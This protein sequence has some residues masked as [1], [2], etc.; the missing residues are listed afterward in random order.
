MKVQYLKGCSHVS[1]SKKKMLDT[2]MKGHVQHG[3]NLDQPLF[4]LQWKSKF[5]YLTCFTWQTNRESANEPL[6]ATAYSSD[7][8][9]APGPSSH[10][11]PQRKPQRMS[12]LPAWFR[13]DSGGD[14]GVL[15]RLSTAQNLKALMAL[16][17]SGWMW[18]M[19]GMTSQLLW[20]FLISKL[21]C[22]YLAVCV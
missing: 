19:W 16:Q 12:Q 22:H 3:P 13:E 8:D 10:S 21:E 2:Q 6:I 11:H 20:L 4:S 14:D 1:G 18:F 7:S 9:A 5:C 17:S 15:G